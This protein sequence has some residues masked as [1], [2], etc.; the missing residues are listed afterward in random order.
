MQEG[1]ID[2]FSEDR[3]RLNGSYNLQFSEC[4]R[5]VYK[6]LMNQKRGETLLKKMKDLK[7]KV[8]EQ[9]NNSNDREEVEVERLSW[10]LHKMDE[11]Q[12][13]KVEMPG[14][15]RGVTIVRVEQMLKVMESLRKPKRVKLI[16]SDQ[17]VYEYLAKGGED[18]RVDSGIQRLV[19]VVGGLL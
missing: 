4:W 7:G 10:Y 19:K 9:L 17:K 14:E 5:E 2:C 13:Q 6:N 16:G 18:L 15:E 8:N 12:S 3:E 1:Y 11:K